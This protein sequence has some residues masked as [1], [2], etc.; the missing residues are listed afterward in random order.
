MSRPVA[1]WVA[2]RDD[3]PI[4]PRVRLRV[5]ERHDGRC[6]CCGRK[7]L[8]GERWECDHTVALINGGTHSEGNL[9]PLLTAHHREKTKADVALKSKVS[10]VRAKHVGIKRRSSFQT[11][12]DSTW[13]KKMDG[14]VVRR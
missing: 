9:Q 12:K 2:T 5:F 13:K 4:P 1:Y 8:A 7:I 11:N 3:A 6:A 14:S 10:R